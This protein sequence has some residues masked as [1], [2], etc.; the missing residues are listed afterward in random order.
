MDSYIR[1][2]TDKDFQSLEELTDKATLDEII[3]RLYLLESKYNSANMGYNEAIRHFRKKQYAPGAEYI[4]QLYSNMKLL[5]EAAF[6]LL[7]ALLATEYELPEYLMRRLG[8]LLY[9]T[10]SY[11]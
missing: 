2:E 8:R 4:A 9:D 11:I 7:S 6:D 1:L 3:D 5:N 10:H